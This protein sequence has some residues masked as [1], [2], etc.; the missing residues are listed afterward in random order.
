MKD[1]K[2]PT[3][4]FLNNEEGA[5]I[6]EV[7]IWLLLIVVAALVSITALGGGVAAGFAQIAAAVAAV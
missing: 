1:L 3:V 5:E 7:G 6:A 4:H 2:E